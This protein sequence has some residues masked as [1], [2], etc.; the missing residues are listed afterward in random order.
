LKI[1]VL[2]VL[3]CLF[4]LVSSGAGRAEYNGSAFDKTGL[5]AE[6]FEK[7]DAPEEITITEE[8][9]PEMVA[10]I[11]REI[12]LDPNIALALLK[13][14]NEK[15]DVLADNYNIS[16]DSHDLGLFQLNNRFIE[17]DF[18]PRYWKSDEPF[19]VFDAESNAFVALSH[20]K[21]LL[22]RFD[23]DVLDAVRAYNGG[24][25]AVASNSLKPRTVNYSYR[26]MEALGYDYRAE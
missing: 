25:S 13:E 26:I 16:S 5:E 24:E 3:L 19:N 15:Y 9:I 8:T 1:L 2:I 22:R 7:T 11:S 20:L 6:S 23:H 21:Y 12:G 4:T 14:E 17:T 18:L 10:R